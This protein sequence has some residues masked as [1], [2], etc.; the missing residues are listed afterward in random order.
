M[1]E[2][3]LLLRLLLLP[4]ALPSAAV[5]VEGLLM[6]FHVEAPALPVVERGADG[7]LILTASPLY[8][9]GFTTV[10]ENM[11]TFFRT[12]SLRIAMPFMQGCDLLNPTSCSVNTVVY[13]YG[14]LDGSARFIKTIFD[15]LWNIVFGIQNI[16]KHFSSIIHRPS[17]LCIYIG[18]FP[19]KM[20]AVIDL[21]FMVSALLRGRV[22]SP[23]FR[24][25]VFFLSFCEPGVGVGG[26]GGVGGV[27]VAF[28]FKGALETY[29]T[30]ADKKW[31][32]HS[33]LCCGLLLVL[34]HAECA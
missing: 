14:C 21:P 9:D 27:R 2:Q 12:L 3:H 33:F 13:I 10:K 7:K 28:P 32:L 1:Y 8:P 5:S 23:F 29:T 19:W 16:S 24:F 31:L 34:S 11:G 30:P 22:L 17:N 15:T 6:Q 20:V 26:V 18:C 25:C 4:S